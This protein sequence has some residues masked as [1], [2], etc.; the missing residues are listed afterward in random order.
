MAVKLQSALLSMSLKAALLAF[1]ST[2]SISAGA[3]SAL[4]QD[5]A[6]EGRSDEIIVSARRR[7]E[8][9]Q[10]VPVAVSSFT[11]DQLDAI[12]VADLT[13]LE[14]ITPNV[15]LETSRST[16]STLTAFI[17]GVGQQDP[18]AGFEAGVGVYLD[19]V[20]LNRP[21]A[22]LLDVYDVERIEILRGPQGTLYGRNTIGGALKYVTRRLDDEAGGKVRFT[23]G[24]HGQLEGVGS[25]SV[26]LATDSAIGDLKVGG[27]VAYL[28]RG[29]FGDN[30]NLTDLENY[31]KDLLSFRAAVEWDPADTLSFRIS[32]DWTEDNSDP[33]QGHR[34]LPVTI[35]ANTYPVLDN[36]FD[37][38][39]GLNTPEQK[40]KAKGVSG[41]AEWQASENFTLKNILAYREDTTRTP[42][43][44][45]SLPEV[46]LDVPGIYDNSQFS[47]EFQ[48][49]YESD[50]LNGLVGFYYL[51]ADALTQF[52]VVLDLTAA[53]LT[54]PGLNAYTSSDVGTKTWSIFGDFTFDLTETLS[55]SAGGRYTDD[56][57]SIALDRASYFTP[58]FSP[59]F[60]GPDRAPNAVAAD[61]DATASFTNFSP[62]ASI[63]WMPTGEHTLYFSY[64]QGFKGGSF[65]PR[66]AANAA[67]D[68][69]GDGL[70]GAADV[71]D[72]IEFCGF[73]P[74]DIVTYEAGWKNNLLDG[75]FRSN[76]AVFYSD[77]KDV[78]VP[79]SIGIDADMD[80]IAETF[81]GV[82]TNAAAATLY[83]LE[84]EGNA[85]VSEDMFHAGDSLNYQ[86][87]LGYIH[88]EYD[89]YL[90]R[91]GT[92]ISDI[93]QFQNTPEVTAYSQLTYSKP[94]NL[95]GEG[96]TSL[97]T[98][99][100]YRSLTHQFGYSS[101]ALDQPG[102]FLMNAGLSWVADD[103]GLKFSVHGTN[104]LNKKYIVAGYDFVT[105]FPEF[106]NSA[107]GLSGVLTA[108]YGN[109][110]QVFGTIEVAF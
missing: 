107:L 61:L 36:V 8:S 54:L 73:D 49:I 99:A 5:S 20:Y 53:L 29:G 11:G 60:G 31:N 21:Q 70:S 6:S 44:F 3:G 33:K 15:T 109:P 85:L 96:Q 25:F 79:G 9:L 56:K 62:R 17:R 52:D 80:G 110:R 27:S 69:D 46:D 105:P 77:Y 98:S 50:R 78:Q 72:Q 51:D 55:I 23:A 37:T 64:S 1:A 59:T 108:F 74:E 87:S 47:E 66:C 100:S 42:I 71:D 106:G 104:L 102:F 93:A 43:D 94:M 48:I 10:D 38:R 84:I 24:T 68:L 101:A 88:A 75:R 57:R 83:G 40:V 14:A 26:P 30:L 76:I 63:S 103:G 19:D 39:A 2:A 13:D 35:G 18:V 41:V 34:L 32:G 89:E 86:F 12:G 67:P 92:D 90:G 65:D 91:T 82:T 28:T 22:A 81:A 95:V 58:G 45:D 97:Y 7:D 16:N 4:A